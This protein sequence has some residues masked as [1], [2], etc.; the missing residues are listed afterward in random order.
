MQT[1][2]ITVL[3]NDLRRYV[4]L[5]AAGETVL[6]TDHGEIVAELGPPKR[7]RRRRDAAKDGL[8]DDE[9]QGLVVRAKRRGPPRLKRRP[10]ATLE[11]ILREL[12]EDR[13]AR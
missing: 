2:G 13:D 3:K 4:K 9:S 7:G 5:A 10:T 11:E 6:V 1:V 8:A 12:R